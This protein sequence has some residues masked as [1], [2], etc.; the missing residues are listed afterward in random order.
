MSKL[1]PIYALSVF[2]MLQVKVKHLREKLLLQNPGF[3][4]KITPQKLLSVDKTN[5]FLVFFWSF[6]LAEKNWL[7]QLLT[8]RYHS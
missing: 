3:L 1:L 8:L 6:A 4:R 2:Q 5:H 7:I